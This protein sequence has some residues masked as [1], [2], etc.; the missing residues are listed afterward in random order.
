[1]EERELKIIGTIVQ[2]LLDRGV[3][4]NSPWM[5]VKQASSYCGLSE[6]YLNALRSKGTG[7]RFVKKGRICIYHKDDLDHWLRN[8]KRGE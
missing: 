1:M 3:I 2:A 5:S 6:S 7:P 8:A 4:Q